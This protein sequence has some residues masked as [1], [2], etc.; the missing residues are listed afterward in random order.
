MNVH[1][2]TVVRNPSNFDTWIYYHGVHQSCILH[3]YYHKEQIEDQGFRSVEAL[4][5]RM[6]LKFSSLRYI[7]REY[8]NNASE[9]PFLA[10]QGRQVECVNHAI[11][12]VSD[13]LTFRNQINW[14]FH[15]DDDELIYAFSS[16]IYRVIENIQINSHVG[17]YYIQNWEA[18]SSDINQKN[19]FDTQYFETDT[20]KFLL[21]QNGKSLAY[22]EDDLKL[23]GPHCFHKNTFIC[24]PVNHQFNVINELRILHYNCTTYDKWREK[25][26]QYASK[27]RTS[28]IF[29]FDIVSDEL[30][31]LP[32][33]PYIDELLRAYYYS[34]LIV[35]R[36]SSIVD[37][38]AFRNLIMI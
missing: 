7:L 33:L 35:N 13:D 21:Y 37:L 1:I 5:F 19:I 11:K 3:I 30:H 23:L 36:G 2:V 6:K 22:V 16:S 24:E 27:K 9:G 28:S 32:K 17:N 26:T 10:N 31:R 14:M 20:S 12:Y 38:S 8:T 25:Y 4:C 18:R 29:T 34:K 15:I